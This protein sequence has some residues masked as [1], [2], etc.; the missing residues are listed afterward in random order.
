[1]TKVAHR[2]LDGHKGRKFGKT[3]MLDPTID[4]YE[5]WATWEAYLK[6]VT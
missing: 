5:M 4:D 1:M 3:G 2:F 6:F